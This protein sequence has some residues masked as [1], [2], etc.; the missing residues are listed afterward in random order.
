MPQDAVMASGLDAFSLPGLEVT[1]KTSI[2]LA[3][4]VI[5]QL[6]RLLKQKLFI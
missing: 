6:V 2:T 3:T 4:D 5:S 1:G